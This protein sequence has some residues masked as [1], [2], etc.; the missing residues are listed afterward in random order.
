MM[1]VLASQEFCETNIPPALHSETW[2]FSD[3]TGLS[4][5]KTFD[6]LW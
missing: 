4:L 2:P 5:A 6:G 3:K 1:L